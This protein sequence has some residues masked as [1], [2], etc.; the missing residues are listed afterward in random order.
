MTEK[1]LSLVPYWV[2]V[3]GLFAF[4]YKRQKILARDLLW[5]SF[6]TT[7]QLILLAFALEMIFKSSLLV[8]SLLVSI[9]MTVNS[10][11]QIYL[12]SKYRYSRLFWN[13]LFSNVLAIW[14]I[15]FLFSLDE[16]SLSGWTQPRMLLP[17]MGMLLGNTL[18]GV[19]IA[20]DAFLTSVREKKDEVV[21]LLALGATS[22]ESTKKV[23]FRSL[24]AG[25]NP[26]INSMISMGIVSIPGM[27][28]GQLISKTSALD[29]S[30]V[31]IKMM[32]AISVGTVLSIYIALK[33]AHKKI[34]LSSGELCLE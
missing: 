20:V 34:F 18:S 2:G 19:S 8:V 11:L 31:Q 28:A 14:P 5:A 13:S 21:T 12:R 17:L 1:F 6:R 33:F 26:Q 22:K 27:M 10:S 9:I 32:L 16:S 7:V 15:A 25:I 4:L 29:A 24:K 3:L 23:F 30:I